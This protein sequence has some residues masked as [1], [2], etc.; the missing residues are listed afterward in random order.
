MTIVQGPTP[1][2]DEQSLLAALRERNEAAF[3]ALVEEHGPAMHRLALTFVRSA[4]LADDVVQDAWIGV[5][6]GIDRFEGRSSLKTW[7]LQ[8]VANTAKTRALREARSTPFSA[9]LDEHEPAPAVPPSRFF[10]G[11]AQHPGGWVSHPRPWDDLPESKLLSSETR[12]VIEHEI[13]GLPAG[14]RLVITLRDVEGWE[15]GEVCG[16]L[17]L[18]ES[19]QRVLLHRA[20]SRIRAAL[21]RHL[22]E[23]RA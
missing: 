2:N 13:S 19:N 20:R 21:E 3:T 6:R 7:I 9:L 17:E 22:E 12:G 5:L 1:V 11:G 15:P 8:I 18:T 4:A 14:Q 23:G 16:L 10:G